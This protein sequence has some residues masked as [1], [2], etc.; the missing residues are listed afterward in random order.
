MNAAQTSYS[1][2]VA[3]ATLDWVAVPTLRSEVAAGLQLLSS[4]FLCKPSGDTLR[5]WQALLAEDMDGAWADLSSALQAIDTK[6]EEVLDAL[7]WDYTRLFVGPYKL[8]CPPWESVYTSPKRLMMQDASDEVRKI[9]A[10]FGWAVDEAN[11]MPDHIGAELHFLSL[12][13]DGSGAERGYV[14]GLVHIGER[15]LQDHLERWVPQFTHDM[16]A[17]AET[18]FYKVLAATTRRILD[19]LQH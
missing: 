1:G 8:P 12:I 9:Y 17:A 14:S 4:M 5:G 19:G 18:Q 2:G 15:F 7:V 3:P 6:S 13:I 10:E 16:E 11:V